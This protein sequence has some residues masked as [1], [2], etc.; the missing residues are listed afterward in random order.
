MTENSP[1]SSSAR[2]WFDFLALLCVGMAVVYLTVILPNGSKTD[3]L[4]AQRDAL[5]AEVDGVRAEVD[6]LTKEID[7]LKRDPYTIERRLRQQVHY[8]KP[9]ERIFQSE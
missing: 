9:G 4:R 3:K 6:H 7:A 8:L 5:K 1:R 2:R